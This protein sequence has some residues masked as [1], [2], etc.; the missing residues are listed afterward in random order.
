[1]SRRWAYAIKDTSKVK[2]EEEAVG[3]GGK[4][5]SIKSKMVRDVAVIDFRDGKEEVRKAKWM[6][7]RG[8]SWGGEKNRG[9]LW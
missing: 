6:E 1:M 3:E 8:M 5:E 9:R 7:S 4:R 2:E